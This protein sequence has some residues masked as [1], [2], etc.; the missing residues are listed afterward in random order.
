MAAANR[1]MLQETRDSF[2]ASDGPIRLGYDPRTLSFP[3]DD[4]KK[5]YAQALHEFEA[6]H[7]LYPNDWQALKVL[8]CIAVHKTLRDQ[9]RSIEQLKQLND[10]AGGEEK[11]ALM[12]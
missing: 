5:N 2:Y 1:K 3:L 6:F 9:N 8:N 4:P 10:Q 7:K 11:N 12:Q